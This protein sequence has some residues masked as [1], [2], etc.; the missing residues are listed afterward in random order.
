MIYCPSH[1]PLCSVQNSSFGSS[2]TNFKKHHG[3]W[4]VLLAIWLHQRHGPTL[5][6]AL[7]VRVSG[8]PSKAAVASSKVDAGR[9]DGGGSSSKKR[10]GDFCLASILI[11]F[12]GVVSSISFHI[13]IIKNK[14]KDDILSVHCLCWIKSRSKLCCIWIHTPWC[15]IRSH[16]SKIGMLKT[17]WEI[18][19]IQTYSEYVP[20]S[21]GSGLLRIFKKKLIC[22][23]EILQIE[24]AHIE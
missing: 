10:L 22:R 12:L 2:Q 14:W 5:R 17:L 23:V 24:D 21:W 3:F 16:G 11:N 13:N 7:W 9:W 20:N 15:D 4:V 6:V 19:H 1:S 8:C 18:S